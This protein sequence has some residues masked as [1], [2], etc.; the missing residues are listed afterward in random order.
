MNTEKD[1]IN[2]RDKIKKIKI[3]ADN[4]ISEEMLKI[5][6]KYRINAIKTKLVSIIDIKG[7]YLQCYQV[8]TDGDDLHFSFINMSISDYLNN[9]EPSQEQESLTIIKV[10]LKKISD[11]FGQ[12]INKLFNEETK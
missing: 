12:D 1:I 11:N 5:K 2:V 6:N 10:V 8:K 3:D 9:Y 4:R 7:D